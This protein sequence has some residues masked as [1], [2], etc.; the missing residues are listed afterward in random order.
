MLFLFSSEMSLYAN[1]PTLTSLV[2]LLEQKMDGVSEK[3]Y[4]YFI[5]FFYI[6]RS[7]RNLQMVSIYTLLLHTLRLS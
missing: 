4:I 7:T 2:A 5:D 3:L 6:L 1:G